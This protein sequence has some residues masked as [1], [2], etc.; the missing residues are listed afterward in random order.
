MSATN[1]PGIKRIGHAVLYVS[2]LARSRAWYEEVLGMEAVV[3]PADF[4]GAFLSFGA[5]DHDIALFQ[6]GDGRRLGDQGFNH[7]A[8]EIEGGLAALKV[9]RDRFREKQ[10][11][12]TGTVD[13]GISY[14]LYFLDPDGHQLELF[15]ERA[16]PEADRLAAFRAV[17]VK[18]TPVDL[19]SL[20]A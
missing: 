8:L 14:G 9:F 3:A 2:D 19:D 5:S 6:A 12:I 20:T 10:V 4:P 18:S 11:T 16:R 15:C 17:G 1:A 13:H 7:I